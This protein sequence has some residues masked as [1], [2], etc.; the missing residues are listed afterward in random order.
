MIVESL[1]KIASALDNKG[2]IKAASI[3]DRA[4]EGYMLIKKAQYLGVQGYWIRN[5]RCW[6]NCYRQKRAS[7]PTL[8]AQEVWFEC[9]KEYM[10][11][12]N[13]DESGWNKYAF[14]VN[15]IK[16]ASSSLPPKIAK[17]EETVFNKLFQEKINKGVPV[18]EAV[19]AAIQDGEKRYAKAVLKI[20]EKLSEVAEK[21]DS[22]TSHGMTILSAINGLLQESEEMS[23]LKKKLN[24]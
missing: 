11:S 3:I 15:L 5:R 21:V 13:N 19:F 24:Q 9:Q 23:G 17:R 2:E 22:S 7:K 18:P 12:I 6:E 4:T 16:T 1:T 8:A 10:E 14:D 20:A